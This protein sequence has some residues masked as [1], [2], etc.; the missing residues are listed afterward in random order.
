MLFQRSLLFRYDIMLSVGSKLV[1][2]VIILF[3]RSMLVM[4]RGYLYEVC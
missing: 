1:T 3:K 2:Y 4:L